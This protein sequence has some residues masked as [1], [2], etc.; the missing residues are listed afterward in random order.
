MVQRENANR[1]LNKI[2]TQNSLNAL[3]CANAEL[4]QQLAV[5]NQEKKQATLQR[6]ETEK[7]LLQAEGSG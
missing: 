5:A 7:K 6:D 3:T 4:Q 2:S 1:E